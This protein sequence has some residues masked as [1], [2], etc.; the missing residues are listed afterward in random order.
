MGRVVGVICDNCEALDVEINPHDR[1]IED[2]FPRNG[3][4]SIN[5]WSNDEGRLDDDEIH[6]CSPQCF[7]GF[8]KKVMESLPPE[9]RNK[10]RP[11]RHED[12]HV[13]SHE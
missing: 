8:A 2:K 9:E 11:H 4:I 5:Q 12:G 10:P 13:H 6:V 1:M 3:W 7:Y